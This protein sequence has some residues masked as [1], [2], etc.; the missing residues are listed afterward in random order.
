MPLTPP[1]AILF[2]LGHT[3]FHLGQYEEEAGHLRM[4]E[5]AQNPRGASLSDILE[6]QET[7]IQ[8]K[9]DCDS[10]IDPPSVIRSLM[11]YH[12]LGMTFDLSPEEIDIEFC[13]AAHIFSPKQGIENALQT[14]Q[15]ANLPMAIV[16]NSPFGCRALMWHLKHHRLA[17]YFQF[18]IS[19][20]DYGLK[21]PHPLFMRLAPDRLGIAPK[22]IWFIG[23]VPEID[24]AGAKEI[25]MGALLYN[26]R[27]FENKLPKAD[28]E[29]DHWDQFTKIL[30]DTLSTCSN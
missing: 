3:I 20:T 17:H 25:G 28:F 16:S 1:K 6:M 13:K 4:L 24:I 23:D 29:F 14:I 15:H 5:I 27:N 30:V 21:K 11:V 19:S 22:N 10:L 12:R 26:S 9:P 8:A 18:L 2:D 7:T